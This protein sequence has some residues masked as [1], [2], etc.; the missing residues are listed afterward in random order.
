MLRCSDCQGQFDE[1]L[2]DTDVEDL[3]YE[4]WGNIGVWRVEFYICPLCGSDEFDPVV[5]KEADDE[6][7][8]APSI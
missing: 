1:S 4:F 8:E 3:S 6:T 5:T 7:T 2:L